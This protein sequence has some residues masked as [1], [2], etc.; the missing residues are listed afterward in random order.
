[1]AA[2]A[3]LALLTAL[4]AALAP[5]PAA[6]AKPPAKTIT[7]VFAVTYDAKIT[8]KHHKAHPEFFEEDDARLQL[9]GR[10]PEVTFVDGLLQ[11]DQSAIVKTVAKGFAGVE[12]K[13][14]D[15]WSLNCVATKFKVRGLAGIARV[16]NGI[17][18][19]PAISAEPKGSCID[20]EGAR[21][22]FPYFL[23]WPGSGRG[24]TPQGAVTFPVTPRSIDV[25]SWSRPFRI[26]FV[27]EKCPN[28]EAELSVLCDY[29]M[30]GKL[31]LT[32]VDRIEEVNGEVLLPALDPPKLNKAKTKVTT[33]IECQAGC[34][35]EALI[36]VFGGTAKKP[37]V[38]PL[39][40][41]TVHLPARK[42]TTVS[43][44]LTAGDRAAAK[45]GLLVM[46]LQAEGGKEQ[47]YP[48]SLGGLP[49]VPGI[50]ARR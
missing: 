33:T 23:F 47:V 50:S 22:P 17:S 35:V 42:P 44:P 12:V 28:Y 48:L 5:S 26:P 18:F 29:V 8:F 46:T 25:A 6:E 14:T 27:D 45:S 2:L 16:E 7:D 40:R 38:T 43:M 10:L 9:H 31:T 37:K 30:T 4:V 20:S 11:T 36:G 15:G 41:K 49:N 24:E 1:V 34:D 13:Q 3:A 32:R 39:H 21:P 19:L